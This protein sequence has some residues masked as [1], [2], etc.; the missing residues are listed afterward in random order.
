M[1]SPYRRPG[2]LRRQTRGHPLLF[3]VAI[4]CVAAIVVEV[5]IAEG[6]FALPKSTPGS[7]V[8]NLNPYHDQ[9]FSVTG[10]VAYHPAETGG[11]VG[12]FP[13]LDNQSLC[14]GVCPLSAQIFVNPS[15]ASDWL[16][17]LKIYFNVSNTDPEGNA[18]TLANFTLEASGA[19]PHLF[20]VVMLCCAGSGYQEP[21]T[22][23]YF[24][25]GAT[26][27]FLAVA[28]STT[29]LPEAAGGGYDLFLNATSP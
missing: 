20:S 19:T 7:N 3:V 9:I 25:S 6:W 17:G 27:G 1:A 13:A 24:T 11:A 26:Y 21:L 15:N 14:P 5:G 12:Y 23:I 18:Y 2:W 22:S 28:Y 16:V 4:V 29:A 8:P 10:S